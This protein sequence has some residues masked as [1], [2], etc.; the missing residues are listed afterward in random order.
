M[1]H[2]T[3]VNVSFSHKELA[4][5][6][7]KSVFVTKST[8]SEV[9]LVPCLTVVRGPT[10]TMSQCC[11][12]SNFYHVSTVSAVQLLPCL[13]TLPDVQLV[14]CLTVVQSPTCNMSQQ[15]LR[16]NFTMSHSQRCS[17][18]NFVYHVSTLCCPKCLHT[19]HMNDEWMNEWMMFLLTCDKKLTKSQWQ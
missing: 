13:W 3:S 19:V 7:T 2:D 18:S 4:T 1:F 17:R 15:C 16:S 8:L 11:P 5:E 10:S 6:C 14:P 9:Q 12:R